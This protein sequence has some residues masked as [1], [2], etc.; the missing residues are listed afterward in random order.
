MSNLI[1]TQVMLP[2]D[3]LTDLRVIAAERNWSVSEVVRVGVKNLVEKLR[4][5]KISGVKFLRKIAENAYS[6]KVP[7]DLSTNDEYLYGKLAPD[8]QG[9]K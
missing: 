2:E 4:P 9:E 1:R 6:G 7:S 3:I 5:R 8:Y